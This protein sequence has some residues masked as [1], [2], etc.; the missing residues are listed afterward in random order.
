MPGATQVDCTENAVGGQ[1]TLAH[2]YSEVALN[3]VGAPALGYS[4]HA[5][6][7]LSH[8][9]P[10]RLKWQHS[11]ITNLTSYDGLLSLAVVALLVLQN[12]TE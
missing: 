10:S 1:S 8:C 12:P 7:R 6:L 11:G 4:G 5:T 9:E 3:H 2:W